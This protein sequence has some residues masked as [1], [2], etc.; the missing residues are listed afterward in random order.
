VHEDFWVS[1][2]LLRDLALTA[3]YCSPHRITAG[4][5]RPCG[6]ALTAGFT[7]VAIWRRTPKRLSEG[8]VPLNSSKSHLFFRSKNLMERL[9][10]LGFP[11][12]K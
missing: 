1:R 3:R 7:H 8:A 6:Q 5:A 9:Y 11:L 12:K 2:S 10:V 4:F